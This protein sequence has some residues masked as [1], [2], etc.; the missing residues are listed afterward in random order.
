[1]YHEI[2]GATIVCRS[3]T[4]AFKIVGILTI[5]SKVP[6]LLESVSYKKAFG[7][8]RGKKTSGLYSQKSSPKVG[9]DPSS[10]IIFIS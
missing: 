10:R 5:S 7:E 4:R 1:M 2:L 8:V 9:M 3:G 6:T